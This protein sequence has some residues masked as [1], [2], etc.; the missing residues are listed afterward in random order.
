VLRHTDALRKL[1]LP[2]KRAVLLEGPYGTGKTLAAFL[3]AQIATANGWTFLYCRPSRDN[4]VNV[5][6]TARLYQPAV[7]FFEDIDSMTT[8]ETSRDGISVLLDLFDGITAKGTEIMVVLTTNHRDRIHKAM[9]RPGRLDSV[10]HIGALDQSGVQ[11]MI[12]ATV[13]EDLRA[14][15][16][17]F[18]AIYEVM[19]GFLP[20]FVKEAID[21]TMRYSIARNDGEVQELSTDDFVNAAVGLRPQLELMEGAG[22]GVSPDPLGVSMRKEVMVALQGSPILEAGSDQHVLTLAPGE[23]GHS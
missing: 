19:Q 17:D 10:I 9:I 5:M 2:R 12:E 11:R 16:L 1:K 15:D 21:R 8:D 7:V 20:A 23:N 18:G 4:F 22:E 14:E 3:T 6:A 13:K